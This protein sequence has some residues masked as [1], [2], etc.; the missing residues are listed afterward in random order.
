MR[1]RTFLKVLGSAGVVSVVGSEQE[2]AFAASGDEQGLLIDLTSCM[3]CRT[4]EYVCAEANGL[5]EPPA[6]VEGTVRPT[7]ET[8]WTVVN[9]FQTSAG[10]VYVKRQCM[11]CEQPACAAACLTKAMYKTEEGPVIWR[12][13]K[14]MGCRYCMISC[15]F[16]VPK[17][18]YHSAV[19]RIQ[20]CRMCWERLADGEVPVCV[21][22]CPNEALTFGKRKELLNLAKERI[23]QNPDQYVP[24][25]YG[26]TVAGGT[27]V[28]YISPVDFDELGFPSNL[29]ETS[30][31]EYTHDFLSAVP[32]VLTLWPAFLLALRQASD[33][34]EQEE[35][36]MPVP[37]PEEA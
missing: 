26:E 7:S 4:C 6:D 30:F 33:R 35:S 28:L 9:G 23:Y 16:D 36:L 21:E 20:K 34:S 29:G 10:E 15:P 13:D 19:P 11:H 22:N 27:N 18:E 5:P 8:Q 14:C 25:I 12:A 17:F 24:E 31:P 2:K 32:V 1:R 37:Q 3:G